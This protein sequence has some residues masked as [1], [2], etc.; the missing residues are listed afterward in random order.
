MEPPEKPD[1][2]EP[3]PA[4]AAP[5]Q[6]C[7]IG[8]YAVRTLG[9]YWAPSENAEEYIVNWNN[10]RNQS[11]TVNLSNN[12]PTCKQGRCIAYASLPGLGNYVWTVTAKNASGSARS[13]EMNFE[14]VTNVSTPAAYLPNGTIYNHSYPAFQ[15]EDVEDGVY[16]YR[17]Q[18]IGR[19]DGRI[20][21]DRIFETKDIYVGNGVCYVQTDLFLPAGSYSW[22]VSGR[23]KDFSS[24]WSSWLDFY[25]ECDYCNFNNIYRKLR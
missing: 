8:R 23:N 18:I 3:K 17:I 11:G 12:D 2:H 1:G 16:E 9:F 15:W 7:P 25:V 5:V 13:K 4:P 22:R 20:R 6:E 19:Y 24:G 21:Y 14:I 10:D